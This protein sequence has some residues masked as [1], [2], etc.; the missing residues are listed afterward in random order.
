MRCTKCHYLSFEPEPRCRNCGHDLSIDELTLPLDVMAEDESPATRDIL[1]DL[2]LHM[3]AA[4]ASAAS[5]APVRRATA[6]ATMTPPALPKPPKPVRTAVSVTARIVP[7]PE[8]PVTTELPLFMRELPAEP[9]PP[10]PSAA[11]ASRLAPITADFDIAA[12]PGVQADAPGN[13]LALGNVIGNSDAVAP[14]DGLAFD[15][16]DDED[17]APLVSVPARPRAPLSVRRHTPD[18]AK[19]RAKYSGAE[20]DLLSGVD[21]LTLDPLAPTPMH[22]EPVLYPAEP[23]APV[24][25]RSSRPAVADAAAV[26][27]VPFGTRV[28]AALVDIA[29]LGAIAGVTLEFTLRMA[30]LSWSQIGIL[31]VIPML[32]FFALIGLGYEWM[33]TATSGQTVGKMVM[34]LRV[35]D[36]RAPMRPTP[37]Q[38]AVRAVSMLP[39]GAGL[40]SAVSA[41]GL[42]VQ[43]RLSHTRVVRV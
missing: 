9:E 33:F 35:V 7:A 16:E 40:L 12:L 28:R 29:L 34:G 24:R 42:A 18:P 23:V 17:I 27:V 30:A 20:A 21:D 26:S 31:P 14:I 1:G 37:R 10:V 5:A 11:P 19:L 22:E 2:D 13:P 38:A 4:S 36:D 3:D 15:E 25:E 8:A 39:A 43:D 6:V 41:S 32:G